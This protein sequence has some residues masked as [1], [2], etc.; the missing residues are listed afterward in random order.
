MLLPPNA[1]LKILEKEINCK[2]W[3][4]KFRWSDDL[5]REALGRVVSWVAGYPMGMLFGDACLTAE[6]LRKT[7]AIRLRAIVHTGFLNNY[8]LRQR[9]WAMNK[10]ADS[11]V[12]EPEASGDDA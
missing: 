10:T 2:P 6:I 11:P 1:N 9:L 4:G 7:C 3:S 5:S 12:T 8:D